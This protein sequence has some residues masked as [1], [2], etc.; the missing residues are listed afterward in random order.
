MVS[1][2]IDFS[3]PNPQ[4]FHQ[5]FPHDPQNPSQTKLL[6]SNCFDPASSTM[7]RGSA[8]SSR[9]DRASVLAE[10]PEQRHLVD[11]TDKGTRRPAEREDWRARRL[12]KVSANFLATM[13]QT[14][15]E[16]SAAIAAAL[17]A[18]RAELH[19][20]LA[21]LVHGAISTTSS[22]ATSVRAGHHDYLDRTPTSTTASVTSAMSTS[23]KMS[24]MAYSSSTSARAASASHDFDLASVV[25][26][27]C[28]TVCPGG[29]NGSSETMG[30]VSASVTRVIPSACVVHE[31]DAPL[32]CTLPS[33]MATCTAKCSGGIS[34]P[35]TACLASHATPSCLLPAASYPAII[36]IQRH[37]RMSAPSEELQVASEPIITQSAPCEVINLAAEPQGKWPTTDVDSSY[38][39]I[40]LG[41]APVSM[42]VITQITLVPAVVSPT[43]AIVTKITSSFDNC[44]NGASASTECNDTDGDTGQ[45][46]VF[47][48][49]S[50]HFKWPCMSLNGP[51]LISSNGHHQVMGLYSVVAV[52]W[53]FLQF[54]TSN[55][56]SMLPWD[57][58]EIKISLLGYVTWTGQEKCR[59]EYYI[60]NIRVPSFQFGTIGNSS[61]CGSDHFQ[62]CIAWSLILGL[63]S[64][65]NSHLPKPVI[66]LMITAALAS[67]NCQHLPIGGAATDYSGIFLGILAWALTLEYVDGSFQSRQPCSLTGVH[68]L[69][70]YYDGK[71]R[72]WEPFC[73]P[74]LSAC[75]RWQISW[76]SE[77]LEF[78]SDSSLQAIVLSWSVNYSCKLLQ[79]LIAW[80]F[81]IGN[82]SVVVMVSYLY[83]QVWVVL[84]NPYG[85]EQFEWQIACLLNLRTMQLTFW[86]SCAKFEGIPRFTIA[87]ILPCDAEQFGATGSSKELALEEAKTYERRNAS[88]QA[89]SVQMKELQLPGDPCTCSSSAQRQG[90]SEGLNDACS[91]TPNDPFQVVWDPGG[92]HKIGLGASRILRRGDCQRYFSLDRTWAGIWAGRW[93]S[94]RSYQLLIQQEVDTDRGLGQNG[95]LRPGP[96]VWRVACSSSSSVFL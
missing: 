46:V 91:N 56:S 66:S 28:S 24:A 72:Y 65:R 95:R 17:Q 48:S 11:W 41:E 31:G 53:P 36:T 4:K 33:P 20:E 29:D 13:E 12:A 37:D 45:A 80:S 96:G 59:N 22:T 78:V 51:F 3:T 43:S 77:F 5:I 88:D 70:E 47:S 8:W 61:I 15:A 62:W 73:V 87:G 64:V 94:D 89:I 2:P 21:I 10:D 52:R 25:P 23:T 84:S 90:N 69:L 75:F 32:A 82:G 40:K 67:D 34:A 26:I 76:S 35:S 79:W 83:S 16:V 81:E 74:M 63:P 30:A 50:Q 44:S 39:A 14:K 54:V 86:S 18:T 38:S 9:R 27:T 60:A 6:T 58:R 1:E 19:E 92:C 42:E 55:T 68:T 93:A 49:G 71:H 85:A 7:S 57:P